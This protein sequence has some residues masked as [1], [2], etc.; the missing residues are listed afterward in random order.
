MWTEA[1]I[2]DGRHTATYYYQNII[3]CVRYLIRQVPYK[4]DMLY[5][6]LREY[7]S[8]GE[9]VYYEMDTTNWLWDT[10]I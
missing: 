5:T 1:V 6:P 10:E 3:G 8:S 4:S 7:D 2:D 9:R